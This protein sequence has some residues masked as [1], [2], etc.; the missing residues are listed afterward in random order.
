MEQRIAAI[1]A[2]DVVGAIR[3][4]KTPSLSDCPLV[5]SRLSEGAM[6]KISISTSLLAIVMLALTSAAASAQN[7]GQIELTFGMFTTDGMAEQ[8]VF[9]ANPANA[10]EVIRIS[11]AQVESFKNA[12]L[13]ASA[14]EPPFEPMK[15]EPTETYPM[16]TGLGHHA[17]RIA[18]KDAGGNERIVAALRGALTVRP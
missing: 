4:R 13:Y 16:G 1:R 14:E 10:N 6:T 12:K 11:A 18:V 8:D 3:S 7:K 2:A 9:I 17:L 5:R 15:L